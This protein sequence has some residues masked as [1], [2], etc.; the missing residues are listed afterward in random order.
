MIDE[1]PCTTVGGKLKISKSERQCVHLTGSIALK[2]PADILI[3][4]ITHECSVC[5]GTSEPRP[6]Q[7]R[8]LE[9]TRFR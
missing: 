6:S 5:I 1:K 9:L 3:L 4:T 2:S 8:V 7:T